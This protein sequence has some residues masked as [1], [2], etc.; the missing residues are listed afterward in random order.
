MDRIRAKHRDCRD[1]IAKRSLRR[2]PLRSHH[3]ASPLFE[4]TP[5]TLT[6]AI[7][8]HGREER[9]QVRRPRG[10]AENNLC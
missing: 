3:Y 2:L 6:N 7:L 8:K 9:E 5:H 10:Y 1:S 4:C